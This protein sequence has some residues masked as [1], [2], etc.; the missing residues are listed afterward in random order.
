MG[1]TTQPASP[2]FIEPAIEFPDILGEPEAF[3][4]AAYDEGYREGVKE[5]SAQTRNRMI[6]G[7][8]GG[9]SITLGAILLGMALRR[10][11]AGWAGV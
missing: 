9:S 10:R 3:A 4:R 11:R 6:L 2:Q 5:G 1:S 8:V 7:G